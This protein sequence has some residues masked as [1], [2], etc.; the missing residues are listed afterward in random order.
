MTRKSL[1]REIQLL[2]QHLTLEQARL[3]ISCERSSVALKNINPLLI[4]GVGLFAG[5]VVRTMG[6]R[7]AYNTISAGFSAY[8][9][10]VNNIRRLLDLGPG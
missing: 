2:S 9:L 8:P 5:V 1:R 10:L 4:V 6:L 3:Q 7:G